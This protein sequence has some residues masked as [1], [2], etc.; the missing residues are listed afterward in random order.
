MTLGSG[1]GSGVCEIPRRGRVDGERGLMPIPPVDYLFDRGFI[2]FEDAGRLI[3]FAVADRLALRLIGIET[4]TVVTTFASSPCP[5]R[6]EGI[7]DT[8]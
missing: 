6:E 8:S 5:S 2:S 7:E 3:V 4:E 1:G